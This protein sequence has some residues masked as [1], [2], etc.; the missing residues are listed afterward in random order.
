MPTARPAER[1]GPRS[2]RNVVPELL[3][4]RQLRDYVAVVGWAA[5]MRAM[6]II[7]LGATLGP[8]FL[9]AWVVRQPWYAGTWQPSM[10]PVGYPGPAA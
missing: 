4:P 1:P 10:R 7:Q 5:S 6:P 8:H 2:D 3:F 9:A